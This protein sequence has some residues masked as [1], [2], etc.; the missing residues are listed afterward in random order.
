[1][2]S[3][4]KPDVYAMVTDR[5]IELLERGTIPWRKPWHGANLQPCNG[6]TGH[7][8]RG[9]N[10]FLLQVTQVCNGYS[11][12]RWLTYKNAQDAGGTVRKGEK[13]TLVCF[14]K[15][16]EVVDKDTKKPKKIPLLRY[17]RVFNVEQCDDIDETKLKA[18]ADTY[19]PT[20]WEAI[21]AAEV[22]SNDWLNRSGL[23]ER[24]EH[25]GNRACYAP[26]LD[27]LRMPD[28]DRFEVSAE[29]YCTLFHELTHSTGHESRLNRFESGGFG[30]DPYAREEL[31]AELGAA[32][33]CG[34]AGIQ[35]VVEENSAAYLNGWLKVLKADKKLIAGA[36]AAAQKAADLVLGK[37]WDG[38]AEDNAAQPQIVGV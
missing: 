22:V 30:S 14:W 37:T 34:H 8:Y 35:G 18:E 6:K 25:G 11:D 31:V 2:A 20:E 15:W 4:R 3:S 21:D 38:G 5:V 28:R 24:I 1:M 16:L 32:F 12:H 36:A 9:I 10:P 7:Q 26:S 33:L 17:F 29:Y 19:E 13:S 23:R 27:S